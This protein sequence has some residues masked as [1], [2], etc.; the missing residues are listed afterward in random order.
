MSSIISLF[1]QT[2]R[3][4]AEP[5]DTIYTAYEMV[6]KNGLRTIIIGVI[7]QIGLYALANTT[8]AARSVILKGVRNLP[9][10]QRIIAGIITTLALSTL[11]TSYIE[12]ISPRQSISLLY[13][14]PF[15]I[16]SLFRD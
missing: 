9:M 3:S 5:A 13:R 8:F 4:M 2:P 12:R 11:L 1:S 6:F 15:Y 10:G 16:L 14:T 7:A